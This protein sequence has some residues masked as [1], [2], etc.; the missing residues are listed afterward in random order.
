[1]NS[2]E[3]C[4]IHICNHLRAEIH[5]KSYLKFSGVDHLHN[6]VQTI[7]N[8]SLGVVSVNSWHCKNIILPESPGAKNK[9]LKRD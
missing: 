7:F 5:T 1:M 9:W 8:G 3:V 6:G 2:K 4:V